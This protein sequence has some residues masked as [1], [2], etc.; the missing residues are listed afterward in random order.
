LKYLETNLET[1]KTA[2]FFIISPNCFKLIDKL[3]CL[4]PSIVN[5]SLELIYS[6][7]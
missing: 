4:K 5:K 1:N 7:N 6:V 3:N 2:Y